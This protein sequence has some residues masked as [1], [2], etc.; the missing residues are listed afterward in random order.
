MM[1]NMNEKEID[2]ENFWIF[3]GYFFLFEDINDNFGF[4][5]CIINIFIGK[6]YIG[7]KY[8]YQL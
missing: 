2:Y 1:E 6:R 8:F 5:Y 7:C 3:N 4:V